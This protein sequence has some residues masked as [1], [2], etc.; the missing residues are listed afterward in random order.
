MV[1]EL[2]PGSAMAKAQDF[3]NCYRPSADPYTIKRARSGGDDGGCGGDRSQGCTAGL[4]QLY[5]IENCAALWRGR[6]AA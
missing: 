5:D 2:Q 4:G 3:A 1:R 6:A